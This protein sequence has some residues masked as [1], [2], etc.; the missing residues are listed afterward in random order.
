M[1]CLQFRDR[2]AALLDGAL[3]ADEKQRAAAH[4]VGC[5][6]CRAL[7]ASL[8]GEPAPAEVPDGLTE[9]ILA[10]TSGPPC[11]RAQALLGELV[12]GAL[13]GA[14]RD[15]VGA[16]LR[17]CPACA[18]LAVALARLAEDLPG[19]AEAR[20]DAR[21]VADVL[22]RT[23]PRRRWWAVFRDRVRETGL[24]LLVRPRI[25][26]EAGCVAALVAWM[27][28]G[29]SWSPLQAAAVEARTLIQTGAYT[30]VAGMRSVSAVDRTVSAVD[31]T[32]SA[33]RDRA[34]RVA[35]QGASEVTGWASGLSSWSRRAVGA[36]PE[37]ERHWRQLVQALQHRDLFSGVDALRSLSRDAGAMLAELFSAS[38]PAVIPN[39]EP[40]PNRSSR[41]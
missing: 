13:A 3:G 12:D 11:G 37:L 32:V 15:L 10:K 40:N 27:A 6:D 8:Q 14:D 25:A 33:V 20:P 34:V 24:Q 9:E 22:A 31:R 36:A 29:A 28:F 19:F 21:L 5:P 26:W 39:V 16:H 30:H 4:A 2:L 35:A 38:S 7:L 23:R 17:H 1:N 18:T 41:R